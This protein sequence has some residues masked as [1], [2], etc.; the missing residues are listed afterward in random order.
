MYT[1]RNI[2][3]FCILIIT[4]GFL[5]AIFNHDDILSSVPTRDP[6]KPRY[7]FVD[8]GANR[9]DSLEAF[10]QHE[11]AKFEYDFP[12]PTWAGHEDAGKQQDVHS[13]Y[14]GRT[15][16]AFLTCA[17]S[18]TI[19]IYLFE[20]NPVFNADLVKA[21]EH[22]LSQGKKIEIFPS[23]VCDVIDGLRTFYLDT[24]NEAHDYWGSSTYA[25]HGDVVNSHSNGTE[26][27]A[28][29]ISRWLLMNTLPRD[30]VVVKMDIEGAEYD[31]VPHLA[32]MHLWTV[33]D[34]LLVEWH[35]WLPDGEAAMVASSAADKLKAE[36]VQMPAYNSGA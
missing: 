17:T 5:L 29:N 20:A 19:E 27:T 21:K 26:L 22:Y 15:E 13:F 33:I 24:V 36:G 2:A 3:I 34:A 31:I 25:N 8:L 14:S 18:H 30:F 16:N 23:T 1:N 7:I 35:T 9:A 11:G 12:S 4:G 10:L 28:V 32:Q 6:N